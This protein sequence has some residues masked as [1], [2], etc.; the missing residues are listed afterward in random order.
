MLEMVLNLVLYRSFVN[1]NVHL[2]LDYNYFDFEAAS[3]MK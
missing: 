1:N 2:F 3:I